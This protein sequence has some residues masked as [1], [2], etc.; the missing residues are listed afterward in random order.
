[1][2]LGLA[3]FSGI[4]LLYFSQV[5]YAADIQ[6]WL[7]PGNPACNAKNEYTDGRTIQVLK[8][9]YFNVDDAGSIYQLNVDD[10][11]CNAYSV[12]NVK[13]I[14]ANSKQ[15]F[16]V[17]SADASAMEALTADKIKRKKAIITLVDFVKKVGFTGVE[18]DFEGFGSWTNTS[19]TNYKLFVSELGSALQAIHAQ[20]MIDGPPIA[21][22]VEQGYYKWV[23]E[24]FNALPV[25]YIVI[26]A[27]DY[28]YDHGVGNP[29]APNKWVSDIINYVKARV[30]KD[31]IVIGM[32]SYGYH[33]KTG[34]YK[35]KLDT[36]A[37]SQN[38]PGFTT[39]IQDPSSYEFFWRHDNVTY[40]MQTSDS[41]NKKRALIE[42]AG[43]KHISVWHLGG[44]RWFK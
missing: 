39:A 31:K 35:I 19:Y 22:S 20:L 12:K 37:Q 26:M 16:V 1:M 33:G 13:S 32:P 25:N 10:V 11:G 21:N 17:V 42:A 8:P 34:S 24:D 36:Y 41:L 3:F 4:I 40:Y 28:Q 6:A 5:I 15:Q 43:I 23:Y 7:Y 27:Y 30:D 9:E 18:L 2:K 29:I 44:N 38:Y 14:K